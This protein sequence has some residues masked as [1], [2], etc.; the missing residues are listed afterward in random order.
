MSDASQNDTNADNSQM[1]N[2]NPVINSFACEVHDIALWQRLSDDQIDAIRSALT[3]HGVVIFRRQS[4]S[5]QEL[6]DFSQRFGELD[7]IVR[8]D[9]A[10]D[11]P[12]VIRISNMRNGAGDTIGGLDANELDWHTDQSYM[13]QP[14]TGAVL[15][16]VEMP[17]APVDTSWANLKLAYRALPQALKQAVAGKSAIFQ[18]ARRQAGYGEGDLDDSVRKKTPDVTH[19]LVTQDPSDGRQSLYL[20]PSTTIGIAGMDNQQAD[21]LLTALAK[22]ATQPQFVY[23]HRWQPGD[24]VMWDNGFLLHRRDAFDPTAC[25]LLKRTTIRLPASLHIVPGDGDAPS[26]ASLSA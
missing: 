23:R 1:I 22:H 26:T 8:T 24:V 5:E 9:W 19:P 3:A 13:R 12:C 20:D 16:M 18:Y 14:A 17:A 7:R 15:Q 4:I 11:H 10:S 25:R 21:Q 2:I 6:A